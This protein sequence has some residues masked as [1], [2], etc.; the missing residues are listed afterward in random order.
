MQTL[1]IF[2]VLVFGA[3]LLGFGCASYENK[4]PEVRMIHVTIAMVI[5]S[6]AITVF[7]LSIIPHLFP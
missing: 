3:T 6:I 2:L 1:A 4:H 7:A 5:G